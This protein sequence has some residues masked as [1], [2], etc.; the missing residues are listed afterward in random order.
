MKSLE[1]QLFWKILEFTY[2]F[3]SI[4]KQFLKNENPISFNIIRWRT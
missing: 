2:S 4:L 1:L 3:F